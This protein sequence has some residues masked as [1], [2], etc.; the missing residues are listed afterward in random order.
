MANLFKLA[1]QSK[2]VKFTKL[3]AGT[4]S[5]QAGSVAISKPRDEAAEMFGAFR[6]AGFKVIDV[7]GSTVFMHS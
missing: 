7:Q 4:I 1:R 3:K 2:R 5:V 6:K